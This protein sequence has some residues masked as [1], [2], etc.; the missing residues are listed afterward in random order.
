MKIKRIKAGYYTTEKNGTLYEIVK[1]DQYGG[2][3]G[4]PW[5]VYCLDDL[6]TRQLQAAFDTKSA[7]LLW[8]RDYAG[9][10]I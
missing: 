8:I 9:G 5:S 2:G 10:Q 6:R 4:Y 1:D 3:D 7:S